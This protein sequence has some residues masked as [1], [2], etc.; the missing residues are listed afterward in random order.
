MNIRNEVN[1]IKDKFDQDDV[2]DYHIFHDK[3]VQKK[4]DEKVRSY[5]Y[6]WL[7]KGWMHTVGVDHLKEAMVDPEHHYYFNG[8][9][10]ISVGLTIQRLISRGS[11]SSFVDLIMMKKHNG[12]ETEPCFPNLSIRMGY[13]TIYNKKMREKKLRTV[14]HYFKLWHGV[15]YPLDALQDEIKRCAD[16]PHHIYAKRPERNFISSYIIKYQK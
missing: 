5:L 12:Y 10:L 14:Q 8:I 9:K 6:N 7:T 15:D 16:L 11:P 1:Q 2:F 13:M 3:K 4:K